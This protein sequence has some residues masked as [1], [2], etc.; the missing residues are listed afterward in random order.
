MCSEELDLAP[1]SI[2]CSQVSVNQVLQEIFI[3]NAF[4]L[5]SARSIFE[6]RASSELAILILLSPVTP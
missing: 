3:T 1:D 5:R 6:R 2:V 4:F